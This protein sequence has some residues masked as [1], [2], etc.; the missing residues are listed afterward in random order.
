MNRR[1]QFWGLTGLTI[2]CV[3]LALYVLTFLAWRLGDSHS[4]FPSFYSPISKTCVRF[5]LFAI[6]F[7]LVGIVRDTKKLKAAIALGLIFPELVIM[8]VLNGNW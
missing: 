7:G 8:G 1:G 2:E 4:S 3:S 5:A 6:A